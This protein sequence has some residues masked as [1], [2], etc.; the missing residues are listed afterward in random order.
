[1]IKKITVFILV[2]SFVIGLASCDKEEVFGHAELRLS[3]DSG[4]SAFEAESFDAAYSNGSCIV[5]IYRVSFDAGALEGIPDFLTPEQFARLY[6]EVS[7]REAEIKKH[8]LVPYYEYTETQEGIV[9]V[10]LAS[11]FRSRFAYFIVLFAS[12]IV[13]YDAW[14]ASF[15]SYTDT[16][17]FV[18]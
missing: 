17:I 16:V 9:N 1:M 13:N 5:G 6:L 7:G 12:P 11:F 14:R 8:G 3:L 4:F 2:A 15:L 18:Y 10:Y